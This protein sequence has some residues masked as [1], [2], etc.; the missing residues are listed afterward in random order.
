[1]GRTGGHAD[2]DRP[3]IAI[4]L[5]TT[6]DIPLLPLIE[7]SAGEA[8]RGTAHDWIADDDNTPAEAYPPFIAAGQVRVA[9]IEGELVGYVRTGVFGDELHVFELDVRHDR[10]GRGI[11][12]ALMAAARDEA[13]SR[14]CR[15]M[16]LTTFSNVPFNAPFYERLGFVIVEVPSPRL[17]ALLAAEAEHGLT[18]RCAMRAA[19]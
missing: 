17:V 9:E 7:Q 3:L 18:D 19:L 1:M 16:T 13:I 15:A 14:D 2:R 8:F 12:K 10:Q 4:R 11:G 5:A 6:A